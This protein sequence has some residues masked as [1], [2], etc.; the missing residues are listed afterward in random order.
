M[1]WLFGNDDAQPEK[2]KAGGSAQRTTEDLANNAVET[3]AALLRLLGRYSFDV[4]ERDAAGFN[5]LCDQWARHVLVG[6]PAPVKR[7]DEEEP[8]EGSRDWVALRR[9]IGSHRR[10]EQQ[11]VTR[12]LNDL[13]EVTWAFAN[14]LSQTV[15]ED[16]RASQKLEEQLKRLHAA[17]NNAGSTEDIKK[18]ALEIAGE[19]SST[20][21]E[22]ASRRDEQVSK[23]GRSLKVMRGE[24]DKAKKKMSTDALTQVFNRA[25]FDEQMDRVVS[26]GLFSGQ[27]GCLLMVDVDH[28]KKI[29]DTMGHQTGDAVL[30]EVARCCR[31]SFPRKTDFVARYGGEEFGIIL[32][33]TSLADAKILSERL[34]RNIRMLQFLHSGKRVGVTISIGLA[35]LRLEDSPADWVERADQCLYKAKQ[36]GRDRVVVAETAAAG[37]LPSGPIDDSVAEDEAGD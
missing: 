22:H 35:E 15:V 11:H 5:K 27:P 37:P 6:T 13:R 14:N 7:A 21:T 34:L 30:R 36:T 28:F 10:G 26:I 16:R 8:L 9:F 23:L 18:A 29:N 12:S 4:S 17:T 19:M 3:I 2:G 24:L 25:A 20:L 31:R 32:Q 1:S 33:D